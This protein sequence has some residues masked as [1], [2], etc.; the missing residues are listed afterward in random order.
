MSGLFIKILPRSIPI[1][2]LPLLQ[3]CI[4]EMSEEVIKDATAPYCDGLHEIQAVEN[5]WQT[6]D[7]TLLICLRGVPVGA[8]A[9]PGKISGRREEA[10]YTAT[11]PGDIFYRQKR[12]DEWQRQ[13]LNAVRLPPEQTRQSCPVPQPG[14]EAVAIES[15][16]ADRRKRIRYKAGGQSYSEIYGLNRPEAAVFDLYDPAQTTTSYQFPDSWDQTTLIVR[17][18]G[19]DPAES[20]LTVYR[21][22]Q[23]RGEIEPETVVESGGMLIFDVLF[24][25]IEGLLEDDEEEPEPWTPEEE[26]PVQCLTRAKS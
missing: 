13:G 26:K 15:V 5:A 19:T 9:D 24:L 2:L 20:R 1:L 7:G 17:R 3:G 11:I 8:V 14:W 10:L 12:L 23:A 21:L 22:Q 6:P 18:A 16:S 4:A 25:V